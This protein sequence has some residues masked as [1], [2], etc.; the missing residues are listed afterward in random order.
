MASV[1][2]LPPNTHV[3]L[4]DV[5][6]MYTNIPHPRLY[7]VVDWVLAR[8]AELC[9]GLTVFVPNSS[10]RKPCQGD[11]PHAGVAGHTIS[12]SQLSEVLKWD[13]AHI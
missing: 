7:E 11:Y 6:N 12:L 9:P 13:I 2:T 1:G 5:K 4:G 10:A 3:Y 8:A